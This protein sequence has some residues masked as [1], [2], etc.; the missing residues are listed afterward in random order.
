MNANY[1]ELVNSFQNAQR[2]ENMIISLA[3]HLQAE[4]AN[5]YSVDKIKEE[6]G[7]LQKSV[8]ALRSYFDKGVIPRSSAPLTDILL[9]IKKE[10]LRLDAAMNGYIMH[11]DE[12]TFAA[13]QKE[14]QSLR[15]DWITATKALPLVA[16]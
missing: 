13:T 10:L 15:N 12:V 4:V 7:R 5:Q 14:L 16:Q 2:Y 11:P 8:E 9:T 3:E 6:D 1:A